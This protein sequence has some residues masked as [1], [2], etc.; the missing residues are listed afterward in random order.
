[1]TRQSGVDAAEAWAEWHP[2]PQEMSRYMILNVAYVEHLALTGGIF[3]G[4]IPLSLILV[5][6]T[7]DHVVGADPSTVL[8]WRVSFSEV[9]ALRCIEIGGW[10]GPKPY[11]DERLHVLKAATWEVLNSHWLT[12]AIPSSLSQPLR[13]PPRHFVIA[14]S[15]EVWDIAAADWTVVPLGA[16]AQVWSQIKSRWL[17][18]H[19]EIPVTE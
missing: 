10:E 15:D 12:S 1:M 14:S 11:G 18:E 2:V 19:P 9:R 3:A 8:A 16:W 7:P 6:S 5:S 17:I 4:G 13:H